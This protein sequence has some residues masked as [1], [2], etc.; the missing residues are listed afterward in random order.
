MIYETHLRR[1]LLPQLTEIRESLTPYIDIEIERIP[2]ACKIYAWATGFLTH[3]NDRKW[4]GQEGELLKSYNALLIT[5]L[6][7]GSICE[8]ARIAPNLEVLNP[9]QFKEMLEADPDGFSE[10]FLSEENQH[11]LPARRILKVVA[12]YARSHFPELFRSK[13]Q[14]LHEESLWLQLSRDIRRES[15]GVRRIFAENYESF[16]ERNKAD[17]ERLERVNASWNRMQAEESEKFQEWKQ[18]REALRE[19]VNNMVNGIHS[20]FD[21]GEQKLDDIEKKLK[22]LNRQCDQLDRTVTQIQQAIEDAKGEG[23]LGGIIGA[24]VAI[25]AIVIC[26]YFPPAAPAAAGVASGSG[27]TVGATAGT[28]ATSAGSTTTAGL[29]FTF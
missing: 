20:D 22:V 10:R 21:D 15:F 8:A 11:F 14:A 23:A 24:A 19:E 16:Q 29:I 26:I 28:T 13:E 3:L 2:L 25:V 1:Q 18:T 27:A 12:E 17:Q 9:S 6:E 4:E 5:F 7:G